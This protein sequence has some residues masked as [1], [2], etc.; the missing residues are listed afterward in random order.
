M[1]DPVT[2]GQIAFFVD[3]T[4]CINC[5]TCEIACKDFNDS[6]VGQRIRKV[7][8]FEG[9]E[10][11]RVFAYNI[12]MS[13][14]HCEDPLCARHCP[15]GA[16]KKRAG[17]GI[18]VHDPE[19]CIGCRYCTWLCPYGAPQYDPREGRVRKCNLCLDQLEAGKSPVC[20]AACPMRAI[21]I[22][23]LAEIAARPGVAAAI[24]NLPSPGLTKPS[25]RYKVRQEAAGA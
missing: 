25:C 18:V 2:S 16:Y 7:R 20:V 12:S 14:N 13:C 17:D 8:V 21:E 6:P 23:R 22:G 1:E 15:T 19:R 10:F 24:H 11:P 5:R 3:T 9:G 4:K